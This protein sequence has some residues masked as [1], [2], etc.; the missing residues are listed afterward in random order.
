VSPRTAFADISRLVRPNRVAVV[1]ASDRPGSLGYSTYYNVRNNSVIAG[2][3]VPVNPRYETVLGDRCY[4][5]V[6][7]VSGDPIDVAIV[8]VTADRVLDVVKDC[9][10]SGVRHLVVLSSGFS[11][12][13]EDGRA[14]QEEM[15]RLARASGMRVCGPN[16]PGL[17][18]I[19]DRVLLSMSPVAG[20]DV[21]SG[22]VGLVTQGGG[23][24]RALMQ[25]MD[26]GL[27]IG[28]WCSPGCRYTHGPLNLFKRITTRDRIGI[29][30]IEQVDV[31]SH[32]AVTR[33]HMEEA[34]VTSEA[35]AEFSVPHTIAMTA[36]DIP[37]GPQW[38]AP[39]YWNDPTVEAIKQ[40]V[41]FHVSAEMDDALLNE[42]L[43]T[44]YRST[45]PHAVRVRTKDGKVFEER[46]DHAPGDPQT[47]ETAVDA[48]ELIE[49]F[50]NFAQLTLPAPAIEE[51]VAKIMKLDELD[52]VRPL[53][54]LINN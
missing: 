4:P 45:S 3:T 40:R 10:A 1:G 50:H 6:S 15:V 24:G 46:S 37:P 53:L 8:L 38:V 2:G 12:T 5:H 18:N 17:A 14:Q 35:D 52:D 41:R 44:G 9:A 42:S 22:P 51:C 23:L 25:W 33:F 54:K 28:L 43:T 47:P 19:A 39:R 7:D 34:T 31:W 49:K 20:A 29:E 27:G 36:F 30:D 21:T 32:S 13:G 11:E 26:R 48:Q 16:S